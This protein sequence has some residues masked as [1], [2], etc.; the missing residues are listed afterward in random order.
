MMKKGCFAIL[1]ILIGLLVC[2]LPGCANHE[3]QEGNTLSAISPSLAKVTMPFA[4]KQDANTGRDLNMYTICYSDAECFIVAN[5]YDNITTAYEV[6]FPE[7]RTDGLYMVDYRNEDAAI[8]FNIKSKNLIYSAVPYKNG[9]IFVE[10]AL[11]EHTMSDGTH[12][13]KWTLTYF[14]GVTQKVIDSGYSRNKLATEITLVNSVPVYVCENT[15]ADAI[16]VSVN[17]VAGL[18]TE[19]IESFAG[20]E[21]LDVLQTNGNTFFLHLYDSENRN[22]VLITGDARK[23]HSKYEVNA[24]LNSCSITK[25]YAVASMGKEIGEGS[26]IGISFEGTEEKCIDE[27]R[28]LWRMTGSAGKYCVA[29]DDGFN[30]YYIDIDNCH[31]DELLLPDEMEGCTIVKSFHPAGEDTFLLAV[32]Y[33]EFYIM[34]LRTG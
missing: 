5:V 23:I 31:I 19:K 27:T 32:N 30:P 8:H 20:F 16:E 13:Y 28:K 33:R 11:T 22:A 29:V 12:T 17:R 14:D 10:S 4:L 2:V 15:N 7:I 21:H 25:N 1:L 18:N 3:E 24:L 26:V 6:I 9:I 34:N